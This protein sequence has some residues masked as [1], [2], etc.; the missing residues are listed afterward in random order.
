L[1][2]DVFDPEATELAHVILKVW[3]GVVVEAQTIVLK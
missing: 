2:D 1:D 3:R